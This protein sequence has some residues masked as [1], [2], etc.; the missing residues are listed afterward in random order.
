MS[1]VCDRK[2]VSN[3]RSICG[4]ISE[5][6]SISGDTPALSLGEAA[7]HGCSA[8]SKPPRSHVRAKEGWN[9]ARPVDVESDAELSGALLRAHNSCE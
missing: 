7:F 2:G 4:L 8:A 5:S 9:D 1:T 6:Y 3:L